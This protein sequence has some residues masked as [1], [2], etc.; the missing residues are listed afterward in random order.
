M[1]QQESS[2][3]LVFFSTIEVKRVFSTLLSF[4]EYSSTFYVREEYK[5]RI[6]YEVLS[7]MKSNKGFRMKV[8]FSPE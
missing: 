1:G 2:I 8:V 3:L 5:D 7:S 4:I 6:E